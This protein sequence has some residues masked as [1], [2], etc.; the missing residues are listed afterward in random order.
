MVKTTE[1]T[2]TEGGVRVCS[3]AVLPYF[4]CGF[5]VIF[6]LRFQNTKRIA[7]TGI[8]T[9]RSQ[10]LV[11]K[12]SAVMTFFRMVSIRLFCKHEIS[13]LPY[14]ASGFIISVYN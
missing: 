4:W 1:N 2:V 14:N 9:S 7:V 12:V 11:K 10:L 5:A 13:V 6:I 3:D 8:T